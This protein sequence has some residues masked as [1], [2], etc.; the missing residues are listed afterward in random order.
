[1]I[2]IDID[3]SSSHISET[4]WFHATGL[5]SW[6]LKSNIQS[7][8][9]NPDDPRDSQDSPTSSEPFSIGI[10]VSRYFMEES[11]TPTH[12]KRNMSDMTVFLRT[13]WRS[14]TQTQV[15]KDC[16]NII[17]LDH[18]IAMIRGAEKMSSPGPVATN[19]LLEMRLYKWSSWAQHPGT[20]HISLMNP[21]TLQT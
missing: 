3:S 16:D 2:L 5:P 15:Q 1:M 12:P 20:F 14:N 13:R 6:R 9:T 8:P 19:T 11:K 17:L 21:D 18:D 10:Y 4:I 7:G